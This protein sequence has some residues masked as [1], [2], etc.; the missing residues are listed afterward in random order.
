[1]D[2]QDQ[3]AA[4]IISA[5][6]TLRAFAAEVEAVLV[7]RTLKMFVSTPALNNLLQPTG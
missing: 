1:M 2:S 5:V 3:S 6:L 4:F 7:E